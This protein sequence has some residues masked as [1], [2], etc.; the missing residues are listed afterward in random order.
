QR[1]VD[2]HQSAQHTRS[3]GHRVGKGQ[4]LKIGTDER[5]FTDDTRGGPVFLA[6]VDPVGENHPAHEYTQGH[7]RINQNVPCQLQ[8]AY[9]LVEFIKL[10]RIGGRVFA[11]PTQDHVLTAPER[12]DD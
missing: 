8:I 7:R 4:V 9:N 3:G 11:E 10:L 6:A 5:D 1:V 12:G 2:R